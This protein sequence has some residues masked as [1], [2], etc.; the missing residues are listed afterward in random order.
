MLLHQIWQQ[1]LLLAF[2]PCLGQVYGL[3]MDKGM[4]PAAVN[5]PDQDLLQDT[6]TWDSVC[7]SMPRTNQHQGQADNDIALSLRS[8]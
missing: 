1:L 5:I 3:A 7:C 2:L 8:R 6:V 4:G